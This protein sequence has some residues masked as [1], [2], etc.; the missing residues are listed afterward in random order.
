MNIIEGFTF[1]KEGFYDF[2][3]DPKTNNDIKN[4]I[5][6]IQAQN[7]N[8]TGSDTV[9]NS[10]YYDISR[11]ITNYNTLRAY[12]NMDTSGSE[13][14]KLSIPDNTDKIKTAH[15]V[16]KEDVNILLLQQNYIYILGSITCATLLIGALMI[17]RK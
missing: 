4:N 3:T 5:Q 6:T 11:N 14:N 12:M 2:N 1:A 9:I 8:L 16:R 13:Y 15:D 10:N 7:I 17:S